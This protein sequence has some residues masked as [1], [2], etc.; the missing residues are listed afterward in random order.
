MP[1]HLRSGLLYALVECLIHLSDDQESVS[2]LYKYVNSQL[3]GLRTQEYGDYCKRSLINNGPHLTLKQWRAAVAD[4]HEAIQLAEM[5]EQEPGPMAAALRVRLLLDDGELPHIHGESADQ[6]TQERDGA[7]DGYWAVESI[8]EEPDNQLC[9]P[10]VQKLKMRISRLIVAVCPRDY[11]DYR[12]RFETT[13][14]GSPWSVAVGSVMLYARWCECVDTLHALAADC[15]EQ[16]L[17]PESSA[18]YQ[19]M[20][21]KLLLKPGERAPVVG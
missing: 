5:F 14:G 1:R 7:I 17:E 15:R 13:Y 11:M 10:E 16:G 4:L 6:A 21:K 8:F 9:A 2:D 12:S 20:L 18:Q 19:D 3:R